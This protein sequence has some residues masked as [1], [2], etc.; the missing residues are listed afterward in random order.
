[1]K[2][3]KGST[4]RLTRRDALALLACLAA[5]RMAAAAADPIERAIPRT[6]EKLPAL[7][8]GTWQVL[9]VPARGADFD[10]AL[11]AVG[12]SST[13]EAVSSTARRCTA[14]P[15]SGLATSWLRSSRPRGLSS[16][17]R[18]GP[19]G[20]PPGRRNSRTPSAPA[21]EDARSR[22]GP[23]SPG[24]RRA[25]TDPAGCARCRHAPVH[26]RDTLPRER[27]CG[28]RARDPAEA[29]FPADHYSLAEPEAGFACCRLPASLASPCWSIARSRRRDDRSAA[30]HTLPPVAGGSAA[31]APRSSRQMGTRDPAVS[32]PRGDA[33][34]GMQPRTSRPPRARPD[35]A[36]AGPSRPGSHRSKAR[37]H[38][39]GSGQGGSSDPWRARRI[40]DRR[41]GKSGRGRESSTGSRDAGRN[42]IAERRDRFLLFAELCI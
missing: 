18:S 31:R 13:P 10:T 23:Q 30:G 20:A 34:P 17:P 35:T 32:R 38:A 26:W 7:G 29:G 2:E 8:L 14:V 24:S 39:G 33:N 3:R 15:R 1:M 36:N 27:S 5:P 40:P 12:A 41:A 19:P 42:R 16:R 9:D 21:R 22:A 28:A 11:A 25:P 37:T 6:A 4:P